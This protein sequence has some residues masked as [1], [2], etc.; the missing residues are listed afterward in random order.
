VDD[1]AESGLALNDGVRDAHLAAES[2]EEDDQLDRVNV[3]GDKHEGSLLI[4][5][6]ANNVV[7]AILDDVG[8]LAGILLLLSLLDC[9]GLLQQTRLLLGL[10]RGSVLV[11]ELEGLSCGVLVEDRL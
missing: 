2:R 4:L 3:I 5:N 8:L 1:G 11:Q 7:E 9:S 6:Q 10:R